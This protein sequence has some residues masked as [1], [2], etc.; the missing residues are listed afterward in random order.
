MRRGG[1]VLRALLQSLHQTLQQARARLDRAEQHVFIVGMRA[2]AIDAESIQ[3]CLLAS[4]PT[5]CT[6]SMWL[7]TR[8]PG[9]WRV[10]SQ[11]TRRMSPSESVVGS[12]SQAAPP[13]PSNDFA[14]VS[15]TRLTPA[16]LREG[17]SDRKSV[18]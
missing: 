2:V 8:M 1:I 3:R 17:L 14:I 15:S 10:G 13:V 11:R 18:V 4:V 9:S 16:A 12:R 7:S 5:G 6:V